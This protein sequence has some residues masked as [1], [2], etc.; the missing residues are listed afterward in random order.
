MTILKTL[1]GS[2]IITTLDI[3]SGFYNMPIPEELQQYCGLVTWEGFF[4]SQVMQLE[5]YP[6][7]V[8]F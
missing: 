3:K 8:H 7:R 1:S 2:S 5:F 6:A 4:I